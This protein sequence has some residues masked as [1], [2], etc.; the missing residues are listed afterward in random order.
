MTNIVWRVAC[1][2]AAVVVA[3]ACTTTTST[4][5][6]G[7]AAASAPWVADA[8]QVASAL[9]PKLMSVLL[10]SIEKDGAAGAVQTCNVEAPKLGKQASDASGWSVRRVSL[11]NRN[12]K[13]VPDDWERAVL[14]DFDRRAAAGEKP[15]TLERAD[16]V[17][18]D[19]KRTLR[20]MKA[21]P[22]ADM[23]LACHGAPAGLA[24]GVGDKLK[25][26]YPDDRATGYKVGDIRGAVTLR[27]PAP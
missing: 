14:A 5:S 3:T 19:G 26:L 25:A 17:M 1:V 16:E 21:L 4:T 12:P 27:K 23:C 11:R 22:V 13:A 18:V 24:P 10:P 20:Y 6:G 15:Q 8:R 9:P 7:S 2:G